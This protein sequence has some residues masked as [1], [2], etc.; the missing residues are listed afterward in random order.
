MFARAF[1]I[2][3]SIG[4]HR[5][6][7]NQ[8]NF[9]N[10]WFVSLRMKFI[11]IINLLATTLAAQ[12][13]SLN[14]ED[15]GARGDAVS[16]VAGT[17]AGSP[18]ITVPSG[19]AFSGGDIG[20][21][22]L[23]FGAG[24]AT[25]PTNHQDLIATIEQVTSGTN[26]TLS[27]SAGVTAT[28]ISATC[29]TQNAAA[30][31]RCV[32]A[33]TGTNTIIKIPA[34]NYLLVPPGQLAAVASKK[35]GETALSAVVI[36]KGG[37]H[38]QGAGMNQTILTGCGA[39]RLQGKLAHRGLLFECRGPVTNNTPLVFADLTMDGGVPAGNTSNHG[40]PA[41]VWDGSGWDETHD[42]VMD[43]GQAPLHHRKEFRNCR[44]THWRGEMLKSV[45][46]GWDGFILV[47]NC[48]FDDGNASAF[49][50]SFTHRISSCLFS[51]LYMAMEFYQAY[52]TKD[53]Y[54]EHNFIT[55]MS[56][57]PLAINGALTNSVNP[58]YHIA[59]N[60]FYLTGGFGI[61]TTPA[62]NLFITGNQFV[63]TNTTAAL[64]LGCAGYQGSAINSNIVVSGNYFRG[65]SFALLILGSGRNRVA[66][67]LVC[68]NMAVN[69]RQF[70]GGYGWSTNVCFRNN[71]ANAGL[72]NAQ[73]KG[74]WFLDELSNEFPPCK[75]YAHNGTNIISYIHGGR[76]Q[77]AALK[78]NCVFALDDSQPVKIPVGAV[79][80]ITNEG[81]IAAR[82]HLSA[83]RPGTQPMM[84]SGDGY[85]ILC[86][87]TNG[88]WSV[89]SSSLSAFDL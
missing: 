60:T 48:V 73:S 36:R 34:G 55:A 64:G 66:D 22:L 68:S 84:L 69:V 80:Q 43:S 24:P 83:T 49:N 18:V 54:F 12:A 29:G 13:G 17:V 2:G 25:S 35:P 59:D 72:E 44:F 3:G 45:T 89:A 88:A 20:K 27:L 79:F 70:A 41:S 28:N 78:T 71:T 26:V 4:E 6:Q 11:W 31:Q 63:C 7:D 37:I 74:Q 8:E 81:K 53:C 52:C 62:Q 65:P 10:G 5:R 19:N 33:A 61:L 9:R 21:L 14:V 56:A 57:S 67:V 1:V 87:W 82:L 30:F 32:A 39:W 85:T 16:L 50:M 38:F 58:P 46:G 51:N 76:Q 77:I 15:F 23:L 75:I 42:A 47:T 40:F 86:A